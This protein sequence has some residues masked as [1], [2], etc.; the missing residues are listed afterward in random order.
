[1]AVTF[2]LERTDG[3]PA[4]PPSFRTDVY[5]WAPGDRIE[6]PGGALKVVRVRAEEDPDLPPVLVV[7][8]CLKERLAT[9]PEVP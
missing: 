3:T 7:R 8:T 6:M 2:K 4:E 1:M 5:A 9:Q